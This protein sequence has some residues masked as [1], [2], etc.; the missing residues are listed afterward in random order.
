MYVAHVWDR[1]GRS[2]KEWIVTQYAELIAGTEAQ[3]EAAMY[4]LWVDYFEVPKRA[5][6]VFPRLLAQ[7]QQRDV[8]LASSGP[9]PWAGKR[10]AYAAAAREPQLHAALAHG[11]VGSFYDIYG[12]VDPVEA[13]ALF[14][15]IVVAEDDVRTALERAIGQP[16]RWYLRGLIRVDEQDPRWR[17]W[18]P[19]DAEPGYLIALEDHAEPT[20][21]WKV[22]L[23][24]E[25]RRLG[26][27][28]HGSFPFDAGIAHSVEGSVD[29]KVTLHRIEG[30]PA[31]ARR[32]LG[33]VVDGWQPGLAPR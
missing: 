24:H 31:P 28:R 21:L 22:E 29:G 11:L 14:E 5:A 15:A 17:K 27:L 9:V 19:A 3:R 18:L 16:T 12:D 32:A 30:D 23:F 25:G 2:L 10:A 20:R 26:R 8:L 13:K 4:S 7:V 1:A 6:F 33:A